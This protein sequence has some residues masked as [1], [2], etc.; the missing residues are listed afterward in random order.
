MILPERTVNLGPYYGSHN[1]KT[2]GDT[3]GIRHETKFDPNILK[4]SITG[5]LIFAIAFIIFC[6]TYSL[7]CVTFINIYRFS[8]W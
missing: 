8:T 7:S 6:F 1:T 5:D 3:A 2:N 4:S